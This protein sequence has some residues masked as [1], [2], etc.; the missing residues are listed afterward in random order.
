[1]IMLIP[2]HSAFAEEAVFEGEVTAQGQLV[3][4]NGNEAKFN[5]YADR[6]DGIYGAIG[7]RYEKDSYFMRF[8]A[9]DIGYDTQKYTLD[10]GMWGKFKYD[11]LYN[12]IP[13][14]ITFGAKTFYSGV[15]GSSLKIKGDPDNVSTWHSFDYETERKRFGGGVKLDFLKP[16]FLDISAQTEKKEGIR[17][18]SANSGFSAF[19]E[20]PEPIDYRTD[21]IRIDGGYSK[22][23]FFASLSYDYGKFNNDNQALD[24]FNVIS[25]AGDS[26]TLP[27]DNKYY[28]L[29]FKGA[30]FLPFN[31]KFSLNAATARA[32]SDAD[33]NT[34]LGIDDFRGKVDTDN[35]DL[36]LT[37]NPVSFLD[38]RLFY[39]YYD[40]DNKSEDVEANLSWI[41]R[42]YGGELGF[43]L[44][45][46]LR[47]TLGYKYKK[48]S[49]E[50]RFD[51]NRRKDDVYSADLAWSGLDFA[52]VRAGYERLHR[53]LDRSG[54]AADEEGDTIWRFD[55]APADRDTFKISV[56]LFPI[57]DLSLSIGYKYKKTDYEDRSLADATE[58]LGLRELKTDEVFVDASYAFMKR[59]QVYGYFD[60]EKTRSIQFGHSNPLNLDADN[61]KASL[62]DKSFDYGIGTDINAIPKKLTLKLQYDYIRS[63]GDADFTYLEPAVFPVGANNSNI[64]ITNWDDYRESAFSARA[65]YEVMKSLTVTAGYIYERFR[66]SDIQLEAYEYIVGSSRLTGAYKDP[67]YN[68]NVVFLA[69]TYKF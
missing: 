48:T 45:A 44:P 24:F 8:N 40:R 9:Y 36:V 54:T 26:L 32:K 38:G 63:N 31:S 10:G 12:E 14:N 33:G 57:E 49:Y 19:T 50:D 34:I 39:K 13:H 15:G 18:T 16:F 46:H 2:L 56:D 64:D 41:N 30:V 51:A 7:L 55:V 67:N 25:G 21:T 69:L 23:P 3:N 35:I 43:R 17:P 22:K 59:V 42:S 1:M 66:L 65:V 20:L 28:K 60:Y 68:A 58:G 52:T 53:T 4:I 29:A 6:K 61:W 11:L 47:L 37:S 5:E 62:R 27:P